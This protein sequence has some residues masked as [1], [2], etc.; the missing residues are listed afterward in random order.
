MNNQAVSSN[1]PSAA[2]VG[3][4]VVFGLC[5]FF[6]VAARGAGNRY[7]MRLSGHAHQQNTLRR[8][9]A[10]DLPGVPVRAA[11]GRV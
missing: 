8:T 2:F 10:D 4:S 7:H 6:F 9:R 5:S 1:K 11:A 3:A